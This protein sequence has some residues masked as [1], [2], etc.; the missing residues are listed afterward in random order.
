MLVLMSAFFSYRRKIRMEENK[1]CYRCN[2]GHEGKF[3]QCYDEQE[4]SMYLKPDGVV[5][6]KHSETIEMTNFNYCPYC[7]RKLN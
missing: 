7:G 5:R 1:G 2:G 6:L 4:I 3:V